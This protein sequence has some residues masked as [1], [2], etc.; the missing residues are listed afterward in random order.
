[1]PGYLASTSNSTG[2]PTRTLLPAVPIATRLQVTRGTLSVGLGLVAWSACLAQPQEPLERTPTTEP[3]VLAEPPPTDGRGFA[4]GPVRFRRL[5]ATQYL[6]AVED[7]LGEPARRAVTPPADP[8]LNGLK[9]IGASEL[10]LSA[11][12]INAYEQAARDAVAAALVDGPLAP[13]F[14]E[15]NEAEQ[16]CRRMQI[17]VALARGFRRPPTVEEVDRFYDLAQRTITRELDD[18]AGFRAVL[19]A[20]LQ[21]PNFLYR[22]EVGDPMPEPPGVRRL[23]KFELASRLSF[24][25]TDRPPDAELLGLAARGVLQDPDVLA[26]QVD[27][28]L[29]GLDA[30][31]ALAAFYDEYLR[32]GELESLVKDPRV[33]PAATRALYADMRQ[34]TQHLIADVVWQQD[35]DFREMFRARYSF[36]NDRLADLYGLSTGLDPRPDDEFS[37]FDLPPDGLR[38]GYVGQASFLALNS[39]PVSSSPTLRGKFIQEVLFCQAI[40]APPPDVNTEIPEPAQGDAPQT[41]RERVALH[42]STERCAGCHAAMD[43]LGLGLENFDALGAYRETE[44]GILVDADSTFK[45]VDFV[46]AD[47]LG[48]ILAGSDRAAF[49]VVRNLYRH[50]TGH[51]E[52]P[53]EEPVLA[54]VDAAFAASGYRLKAALRALVLSDAFQLVREN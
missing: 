10:A 9:G 20:I 3:P 33:Y 25:L 31:R 46:G 14:Y 34:E 19:M 22:S 6:N 4:P 26:A 13:K 18:D 36:L 16:G 44:N 24:F 45:G 40:P 21:S 48:D 53:W 52:D 42:L 49:C 28:L 15:C 35:T 41:T 39:H 8:A 2:K 5:V 51:V 27:R 50:A 11:S 43:P 37:R 23:V 47:G 12:E 7:L 30:P 38:A 29:D 1:M 54:E 17:N 32:L